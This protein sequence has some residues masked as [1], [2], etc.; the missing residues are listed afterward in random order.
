MKKSTMAIAVAAALLS[1]TA[2]QASEFSGAYISGKI[3]YNT[4]SPSTNHTVNQL[5]PGLEAG[6]GWDIGS[7]LLGVNGFADFHTNSITGDDYGGDVK[8][9]VPMGEFMPYAKL[10]ETGG[11]PGNRANFALGFQYKLDYLWS[12][13]S[14][15]FADSINKNSLTERNINISVGLTRSLP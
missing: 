7:V 15:L 1:M 2:A 3:G 10:G 6:Y 13:S 14:E 9:G 4:S 8:L 11:G 12:V 5:Y